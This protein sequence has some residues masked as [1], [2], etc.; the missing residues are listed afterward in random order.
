[1]DLTKLSEKMMSMDEE[2]WQRHSNPWSVYSRFTI[3]PL[4][5]IAF[6]S[7]EWIGL[8]AI[9]P[10]TLSFLWI[11]INPRICGAPSTTDNW[12]SMGTFG[13][14]IYLRKATVQIP[15]HQ[16]KVAKLLQVLSSAGV[17]ILVYGLYILDIWVVLLGNVMIMVFKAWFVD[18]MVWLY[19]DV[20]DSEAEFQEWLRS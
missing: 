4:I 6:W 17:P 7:R 13:E 20:K 1:M 19:L 14:R 16:L 10:I 11:W 15:D 9:V 8:Y 18:R 2:S 5:S 3:L 12:A